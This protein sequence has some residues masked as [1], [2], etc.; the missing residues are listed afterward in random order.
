L[1]GRRIGGAQRLATDQQVTRWEE[2]DGPSA[3][4]LCHESLGVDGEVEGLLGLPQH[5]AAAGPCR[6][7]R[8][9]GEKNGELWICLGVVPGRVRQLASPGLA[10]AGGGNA[11]LPECVERKRTNHDHSNRGSCYEPA[12]APNR[13]AFDKEFVIPS[14]RFSRALGLASLDALRHE[15]ALQCREA[16]RAVA[17]PVFVLAKASSGQEV[18]G[19]PAGGIPL[20]RLRCKDG[21]RSEIFSRILDPGAKPRPFSEECLVSNLNG[22][23]AGSRVSVKGKQ[24]GFV[25]CANG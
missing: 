5:L 21:M 10:F 16:D 23:L 20:N 7:C 6:P 9:E 8:L 22:S 13:S 1:T 2:R 18:A 12:E 19:F 14:S 17:R 3:F 11:S 24:S 4:T 15:F 25:K